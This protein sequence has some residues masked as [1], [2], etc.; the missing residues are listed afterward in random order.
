MFSGN[1][2]TPDPAAIPNR[3]TPGVPDELLNQPMNEYNDLRNVLMFKP[4]ILEAV[5][6]HF[7]EG[8]GLVS[9]LLYHTK[10][11]NSKV[12]DEKGKIKGTGYDRIAKNI[13]IINNHEFAWRVAAPSNWVYKIAET[14][15]GDAQGRVGIGGA[16]FYLTL[17]KQLGEQDD[18]I[19]LADGNTQLIITAPPQMLVGG[20]MKVRVRL[21]LKKGAS[22]AFVPAYLLE[23]GKEAK[24]MYNMKPEASEH[25]SK[26]R[27][28]FGDWCKNYMTTQ[29]WEWNLTGLAA[30]T[31]I[32][33]SA[34]MQLTYF[35]GAK[36]QLEKYWIPVLDY[37]MMKQSYYH[38]DNQLFWGK[39][40]I[41]P[42]GSF[43][44]DAKGRTYF[45]GDGIYHQMNRRLKRQYN[46][47]TSFRIVDD[48]L[49]SLRYDAVST[50][51]MK[52]VYM[53]FAGVEFRTQF[54][55]LI[56]NEFKLSPEVLYFDGTG[57]YQKE[58]GVASLHGSVRGIKSNFNYYET[59]QGVFVVS[60]CNYF[61]SRSLPTQ[62]DVNGLPE[63]SYRA[64]LVNITPT[65]GGQ[66]MMS[67]V[68]LAGRQNV[69]GRVNGMSQP[70]P[71]GVLSTTADVEGK[72]MLHMCG[73][74]VHNPNSIG[75]FRKSRRRS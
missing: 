30:H 44:K 50:T 32:D 63:Q 12:V 74:G 69:I 60:Q 71:S 16:E 42:D 33:P 5:G 45:S 53:V 34:K 37:E 67:M 40:N 59:P 6:K 41:N 27:I 21:L 8:T 57:G 7:T 26:I 20:N 55:R 31:Q 47:L 15:P 68:S 51:G 49:R 56:R 19:M 23:S 29:R 75:E 52:P 11:G 3:I 46:N 72:H 2:N 73:V 64:I 1:Q 35:N 14:V 43:R 54:D 25:G 22:A 28:P 48:M 65:I 9:E 17:N 13:E 38:I 61:D 70:G 58:S 18:V 24:C 62:Y 39:K 36:N 4:H 66:D 10:S